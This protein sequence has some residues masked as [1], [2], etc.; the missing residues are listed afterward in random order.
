MTGSNGF[1]LEEWS[2]TQ[3]VL[4]LS[5]LA[6]SSAVRRGSATFD[7]WGRFR[8]SGFGS[9]R[10]IASS[11]SDGPE[12]E[13]ETKDIL[14]IGHLRAFLASRLKPTVLCVQYFLPISPQVLP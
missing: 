1:F 11:I 10:S 13:C 14:F 12:F 6:T 7:L 5:R 8:S 2:Q 4:T 9:S 3:S